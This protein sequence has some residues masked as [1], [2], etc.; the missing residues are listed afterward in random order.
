VFRV[1]TR[2]VAIGFSVGALEHFAG[3]ALLL[4]GVAIFPAPYPGWR[5]AV[6]SLVDATIVWTAIKRPALL[7]PALA[8]FLIEQI[9]V[10][11]PFLWREA[12]AGRREWGAIVTIAF[13]VLALGL[14]SFDRRRTGERNPQFPGS[15]VR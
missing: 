10:N 14:L 2:V 1:V 12:A 5:H 7:K 4:F 6:M 8:A 9:V 13:V 3:A 11:G 15:P